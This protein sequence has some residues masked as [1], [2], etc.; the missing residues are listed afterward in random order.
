MHITSALD[1]LPAAWP[2]IAADGGVDSLVAIGR[3][4]DMVIGDMD[5]ASA[6]PDGVP[7]MHLQGQ[8]DTDL[9]KCLKRIMAPV[10]VGVGFLE[11]RLDHTLAALHAMAAL[12]HD[13]P[14]MLIGDHDV[15]VR[16]NGGFSMNGTLGTRFSVWPLGSQSFHRSSGLKWALDGLTMKAGTLI[17]T[18]N[19]ISADT[20]MIEAD[21]GDGY[22][23]IM[24]REA[25]ADLLAAIA[26]AIS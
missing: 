16:L 20:V 25:V 10:I 2:V 15:C 12:P 6:V 26:T 17:G 11:G 22:A 3:R 7:V 21:K 23:V 4:P 1:M 13:R 18:S 9:E 5:S 19:E 24:P 14:V 8:D